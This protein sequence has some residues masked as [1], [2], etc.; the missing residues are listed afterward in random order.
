M[1]SR[2]YYSWMNT[3][4]NELAR[5]VCLQ[6]LCRRQ[7]STVEYD[8]LSHRHDSSGDSSV[9]VGNEIKWHD[10]LDINSLQKHLLQAKF[11]ITEY[12]HDITTFTK[13]F[14]ITWEGTNSLLSVLYPSAATSVY[15]HENKVTHIIY[16]IL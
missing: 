6:Q 7:M 16:T 11:I 5:E 1:L 3:D 8:P 10:V 15:K 4:E 12:I 9:K 14:T 13:C 2:D